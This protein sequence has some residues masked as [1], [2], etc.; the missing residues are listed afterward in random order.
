MPPSVPIRHVEESSGTDMIALSRTI[1]Y[2]LP[3]PELFGRFLEQNLVKERSELRQ[4]TL[5]NVLRIQDMVQPLLLALWQA[6]DRDLMRKLH[7]PHSF[8]RWFA[9]DVLAHRQVHAEKQLI[10]ML[11]DPY[12]EVR[13]G[14]RSALVQLSRGADFGPTAGASAAEID[15]AIARWREWLDMQDPPQSRRRAGKTFEPFL[16]GEKPK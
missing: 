15:R 8:V 2:Q 4:L 10:P 5:V 7:D 11:R 9:A 6:P 16:L 12:P 1:E 13:L 14:V 3:Y